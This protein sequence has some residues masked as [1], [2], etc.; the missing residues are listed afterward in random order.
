M[1]RR[2][3]EPPVAP[4]HTLDVDGPGAYT[5]L[6]NEL[7]EDEAAVLDAVGVARKQLSNAVARWIAAGKPDD[8]RTDVPVA[9]W[10]V[11]VAAATCEAMDWGDKPARG[12][13]ATLSLLWSQAGYPGLPGQ[14]EG[15]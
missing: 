10:R 2:P 8:A 3:D 7:A 6:L 13:L 1:R 12:S 4:D 15:A 14:P 5:E 11:V 9:A